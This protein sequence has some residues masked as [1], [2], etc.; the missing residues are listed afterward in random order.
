VI[1]DSDSDL[2]LAYA[3]TV[4]KA[5]GSGFGITILVV[6]ESP[7]GTNAFISREMIYTALTRQTDKVFILYNKDPEEF[8]KYADSAHSDLARRLTNLFSDPIVR[9]YKE[10]YYAE[11]LIHITRSGEKVRSKSEVIIYNELDSVGIPFKYE[12]SLS[13]PNGKNFLPDFT[14]FKGEK[15]IYWEHLGMLT[16][17]KYRKD[18]E[19]K[20]K[21]YADNG[22]SQDKGNLIVTFD[23]L[24]GGIDSSAIKEI[25]AKI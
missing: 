7:K 11:N 13:L 17:A 6:N 23:K 1:T 12:R 9:K 2:E 4:H 20:E 25:V 8:R 16:D 24:N 10:H 22:I 3:L 15:E 18:W 21:S 14:I 5:Q 19:H